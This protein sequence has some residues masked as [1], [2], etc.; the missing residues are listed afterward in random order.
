[1]GLLLLLLVWP[2]LPLLLTSPLLLPSP[3]LPP[4]VLLLPGGAP[5]VGF[6]AARV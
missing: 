6:R 4:L 3:L 1:M 5:A 2:P